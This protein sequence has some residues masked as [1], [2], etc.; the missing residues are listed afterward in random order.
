M[1]LCLRT[2]SGV[3]PGGLV[4][5]ALPLIAGLSCQADMEPEQAN[6]AKK[7]AETKGLP[8]LTSPAHGL[9]PDNL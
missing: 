7:T 5:S 9:T 4:A 6:S 2:S 1:E 8:G 3:S